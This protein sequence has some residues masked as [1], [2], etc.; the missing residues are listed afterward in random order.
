MRTREIANR[1]LAQL[2]L[3]PAIFSFLLTTHFGA[4]AQDK[5]R[6]TQLGIFTGLAQANGFGINPQLGFVY[7]RKFS[8]HSNLEL[9]IRWMSSRSKSTGFSE[10]ADGRTYQYMR[11]SFDYFTM[12]VLYKFTSPIVNISAGPVLNLMTGKFETNESWR[13]MRQLDQPLNTLNVGAMFKVGKAF[14]FKDRFVLEPEAGVSTSAY[15][16][17]PIWET[18]VT[19]KYK[20]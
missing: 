7:E 6:K 10:T 4:H 18:G 12:P 5:P 3:R 2:V 17:R 14:H 8:K 9:G 16:K 20:L 15:F 11:Q 1:S 19:L 13:T